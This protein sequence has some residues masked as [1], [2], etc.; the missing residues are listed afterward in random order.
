MGL[1]K[2]LP[3]FARALDH[4]LRHE[5]SRTWVLRELCD[6][7]N[8]ASGTIG[9]KLPLQT[10]QFRWLIVFIKKDWA[11]TRKHVGGPVRYE[12]RP[13]ENAK[14]ESLPA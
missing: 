13:R 1:R 9:L 12:F 4:I 5:P 6:K 7:I 2:N 14:T 8:A 11:V 3:T 10:R